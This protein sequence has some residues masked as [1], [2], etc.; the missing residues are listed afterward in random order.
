MKRAVCLGAVCMTVALTVSACGSGASAQHT[1]SDNPLYAKLPKSVQDAGTLKIGGS[2]TIAPYLYKDGAKVVGFEKDLMDALGKALDVKI[3]FFDTGF[4]ALVPGLQSRKIDVAMG[5][6]TDTRERQQA[7][8]FVDYTT[9]YQTLFVQKGNPKKLS[10]TADLC[11]ASVAAAV[12]SLSAKLAQEQNTTCEKAG[13]HGVKV[14]QMEDAPAAL[15]QVRTKRADALII[16]YVIGSHVAKTSGSGEVAGKPFFQQ[17]HGAA[18]RKDNGRL[19]DA[20]AAAF[21]TIIKDGSYGKILQKW[22]MQ[23]LA[24]PAPSVNA[25]TS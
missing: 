8:S 6:F 16:D 3:Q 12:G 10:S 25:A 24:M 20:L 1:A 5:D 4:P 15:M 17:F 14:L 9:S 19:R 7:V 13:K 22:D 23:K 18:V 2:A 21:E 11:G